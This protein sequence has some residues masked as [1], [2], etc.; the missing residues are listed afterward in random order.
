MVILEQI[1]FRINVFP[2]DVPKL[3]ERSVDIPF[4]LNKILE[5][6]KIEGD[7]NSQ[8]PIFDDTAIGALQKYNWPGNVREL[9]T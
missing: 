8:L 5:D 2:I 9:K 7:M 4:I 1:Y 6:I 3:S